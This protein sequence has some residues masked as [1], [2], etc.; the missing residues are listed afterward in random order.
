MW[1]Q[2]PRN[3]MLRRRSHRSRCRRHL[4]LPPSLLLKS[5]IAA[6]V[7]AAATAAADAATSAV[8]E[9]SAAIRNDMVRLLV[10]CVSSKTQLDILAVTA[11]YEALISS[12]VIRNAILEDRYKQ[13]KKTPTSRRMQ[14]RTPVCQCLLPRRSRCR[15]SR[16]RPGRQSCTAQT[17][18]SR[19]S[20]WRRRFERK[21]LLHW[22]PS[23]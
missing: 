12:L 17:R 22:S 2:E 20:S 16:G 14:S 3:K 1:P 13:H 18:P 21:L 15:E 8:E 19:A 5:L 23:A 11:R 7:A 4:L 9:E 6:E 10:S